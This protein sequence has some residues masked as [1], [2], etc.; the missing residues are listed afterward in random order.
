M[1]NN[2]GDT[3]ATERS[4][5]FGHPA[6]ARA[7][8][9]VHAHFAEPIDI[10]AL[11]RAAGVSRSV[12]AE[13][14]LADT[15]MTPMR[16]CSRWRLHRA[17]GMLL[18]DHLTAAEVAFAVGFGSESAFNRAFRRRYGKPPAAWRKHRR[19]RGADPLPQQDIRS[20]TASDGTRLAWTSNGS[21]PPLIK[22]ANWLNH[23]EYDWQSPVWRHWLTDLSADHTLIRYDERGTGLSERDV[24]DLSLAA[25]VDDFRAVVDAAGYDRFDVLALS[26]G[27]AVAIAYAVANPGR[28]R[29]LVLLGSYARGWHHRL[30]GEDHARRAAMV[31]LSRTGW[32]SDT[33]VYRQMFTSL[34]IPGGTPEQIEWWNELQRISTSPV[35]AE[36]LQMAFGA[37][38]VTDMLGRLTIPVLVAHAKD[39]RVI[40]FSAGEELADGLPNATFLSLD[41]SNH[42]LLENEPAWGEFSTRLKDFLAT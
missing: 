4:G 5:D 38:D 27:A 33:P 10:A 19:G 1:E 24:A 37:I 26:Q 18:E 20:C 8:D 35:N 14:F 39:D 32:G 2:A 21:G 36:R 28:V 34:F 40:P 7:I 12:L 23:L 3:L 29:R 25:F 13:R 31:T 41:S 9:H 11:A 30:S 6:I 15:G 16:Y 17:A 22:T 42:V